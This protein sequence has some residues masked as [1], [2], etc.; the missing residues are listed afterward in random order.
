MD[1]SN[2]TTLNSYE[3]HAEEYIKGTPQEVSGNVQLWIDETLASVPLE[4]SILELGS[5]FGRDAEYIESK[6][7]KVQRTDATQAFVDYLRKQGHSA[8]YF[9]AI[10][11]EFPSSYDLI[12]A[13]AVLLH[14]TTDEVEVVLWK[15]FQSLNV[16]G[17]LS[18]SLKLGEGEEW[19]DAKLGAPRYFH[20]WQ[21]NEIIQ[22]LENTGYDNIHT[23]NG[24]VGRNDAQWLHIIAEK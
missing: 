6:G 17:R 10:I 22:L 24:L 20:Y 5:A 7:Y 1:D 16:G 3:G 13:N 4:A 23:Y 2:R 19:S 14:F 21:E 18:F 12:F 9:N 15:I 11:D 8:E